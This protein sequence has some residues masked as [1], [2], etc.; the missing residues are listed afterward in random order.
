MLGLYIN[1]MDKGDI[2]TIIM[3]YKASGGGGTVRSYVYVAII[4]IVTY[5]NSH[6]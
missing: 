2:I 3:N 6:I 4:I 5:C 1:F